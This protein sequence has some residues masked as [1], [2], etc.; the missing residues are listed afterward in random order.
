MARRKK[1]KKK[2]RLGILISR[3]LKIPEITSPISTDL[4]KRRTKVFLRDEPG[5]YVRQPSSPKVPGQRPLKKE[6]I[7]IVYKGFQLEQRV[8]TCDQKRERRRRAFFGYL[9]APHAGKGTGKRVSPRG[10]RFT[11]KC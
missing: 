3:Q 5:L 1:S 6:K 10:D 4:K 7:K 9:N 11:V 8:T 2:L